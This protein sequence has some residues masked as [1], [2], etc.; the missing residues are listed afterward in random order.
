[1]PCPL[2]RETAFGNPKEPGLPPISQTPIA[3]IARLTTTKHR[4]VRTAVPATL[5]L[6]LIFTACSSSKPSSSSGTTTPAPGGSPTTSASTKLSGTLNGSGSSFQN[7]FLQSAIQSFKSVQPNMTVNYGA[8]GSGK[9]RTDLASGVVNYAGSDSPIPASEQSNFKGTV[10]YFPDVIAPITISYH[11]SG[12]SN[13][14]LDAPVI[15]KIFEAQI[16]TWNDPQITALNP[17][18][19]LPGTKI[20]VARRSDSSGT[21]QNFSEFLVKGA[22][23]VW[24]LGS[25]STIKWPSATVGGNGNGGVASIIKSTSGAVGYV[26]FPDAKASGLAYA[27]VKNSAGD[28]VAPS[29]QSATEAASNVTIQPNLTFSAIWAPGA[30]SYPITYQSWVLVYQSQSAS[31]AQLLQAWVGY[32]VGAGQQL[33]PGLNYAPL[34]SSLQSMTQAQVPKIGSTS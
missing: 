9:G 16:T 21:T 33:L 29:V 11:L 24:T 13:L 28:F 32:L 12:V 19:S 23:G 3:K 31:N 18:V 5:A 1:M 15:A 7:V 26:D 6:T 17:G 14:K 27:S 25:S 4:L 10:L 8:G 34:P 2:E 22:P 30:G 20:T